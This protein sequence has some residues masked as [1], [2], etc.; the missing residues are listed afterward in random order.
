FG[1]PAWR[2]RCDGCDNCLGIAR[3]RETAATRPKGEPRSK[4]TTRVRRPATGDRRPATVV[5]ENDDVSLTKAEIDLLNALREKR[6]E[7]SRK[8]A[9]P[10]YIVFSDRTLAEMA[11]RRPATLAAM[12]NVRGVGEMKLA[13]YGEEFLSVIKSADEPEAA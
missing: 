5:P 7:I 1:D 4:K 6:R 9:V 10:A 3:P 8:D 13:R 11:L 2:P 12:A